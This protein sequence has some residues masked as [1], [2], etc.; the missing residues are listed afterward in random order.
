MC[1][2]EEG[3]AWQEVVLEAAG[4]GEMLAKLGWSLARDDDGC[5]RTSE[6]AW[7]DFRPGF[8]PGIGQVEWDRSFG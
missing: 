3:Q 1:S 2:F 5:W 4:D 8:R 7:H 6:V